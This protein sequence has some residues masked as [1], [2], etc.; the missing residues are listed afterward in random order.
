MSLLISKN[1]RMGEKREMNCERRAHSVLLPNK[2]EKSE[3]D[4]NF[5]FA[6]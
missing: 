3:H 2:R 1:E 4:I 5:F 6:V